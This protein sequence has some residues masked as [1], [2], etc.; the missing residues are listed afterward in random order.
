MKRPL[1]GKLVR[2]LPSCLFALLRTCASSA[3]N[4]FQLLSILQLVGARRGSVINESEG[5][6]N[7][8]GGDKGEAEAASSSAGGALARLIAIWNETTSLCR[9]LILNEEKTTRVCA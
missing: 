9:S 5:D 3:C 7:G 6:G 4:S 2:L 8:E 1:S